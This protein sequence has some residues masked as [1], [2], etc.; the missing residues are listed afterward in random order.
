MSK[1][2]CALTGRARRSYAQLLITHKKL[3]TRICPNLNH[4][5]HRRIILSAQTCIQV[6]V[7]TLAQRQVQFL[8]SIS[9]IPAHHCCSCCLQRSCSSISLSVGAPAFRMTITAALA[10]SASSPGCANEKR[11]LAA[12]TWSLYCMHAVPCMRT[13]RAVMSRDSGSWAWGLRLSGAGGLH[14]IFMPN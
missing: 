7:H 1:T 4:Y 6:Q 5:R 13:A 14:V 10:A 12:S 8:T 11:Y 2:N 9:F 3:I